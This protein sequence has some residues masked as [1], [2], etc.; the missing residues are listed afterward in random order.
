[1]ATSDRSRYNIGAAARLSGVS[2]EKI[3]IW[4]RRYQAVNPSRDAS[5]RRLYSRNDIDRLAL[6]RALVDS[7]HTIS[8]V[9]NLSAAKLKARLASPSP[10]PAEVS[11]GPSNILLI[12]TPDSALVDTLKE[13]PAGALHRVAD[14]AAAQT[15]LAEHHAD[16]IIADRPTVLP[17]DLAELVRL[18]RPAPSSRMLLVYRFSYQNVLDQLGAMGIEAVKAPLQPRDLLAPAA[19]PA[20]LTDTAAPAAQPRQYSP[21]QLNRLSNRADRMKCE[22]PRHLAD[23]IRELNAFEDYSLSCETESAADAPRHRE[24]YEIVAQARTLVERALDLAA[25]D[26]AA[27]P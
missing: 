7:G 13:H 22:C 2:R 6:I 23:L 16:L 10:T 11:P 26:S 25:S 1:M 17:S 27:D 14:S 12:A 9:A 24:I 5:N 3:R 20:P 8:S 21:A 19:A 18:R 4:E 15:W